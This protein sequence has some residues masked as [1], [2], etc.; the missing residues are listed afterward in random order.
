[1]SWFEEQLRLREQSDNVDFEDAVDS[2]AGAVMGTR[3][4]NALSQDE[5]ADSALDEILKYY[6]CK[7]KKEEI[8]SGIKTIDE[9]I[10]YRMRP[11]GI[12]NRTVTLE[13]GWYHHAA[14]AMLGTLVKDGS[15]VALIPGKVTGYRLID[16]KSGKQIKLNRK[17]EKLLDKEALC[18]YE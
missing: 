7:Q 5:T 6:H 2:I 17:S 13:T 4:R 15:A 8:P 11:Y 1:M 12:K 18:F 10:E 3:L 14:G 16:I 9:Q